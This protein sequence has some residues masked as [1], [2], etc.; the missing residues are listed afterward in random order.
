MSEKNKG[1]LTMGLPRASGK[2]RWCGDDGTDEVP[3]KVMCTS[4]PHALCAEDVL[5]HPALT[6]AHASTPA[7]ECELTNP[8]AVCDDADGTSTEVTQEDTNTS[9]SSSSSSSSG[10]S[11]HDDHA[12]TDDDD[13]DSMD[14]PEDFIDD[15]EDKDSGFI[16]SNSIDNSSDEE[17]ERRGAPCDHSSSTCPDTS[18]SSSTTTSSTTTPAST[19]LQLS[20]SQVLPPSTSSSTT[21]SSTTS[22]STTTTTS[23]ST[24]SSTLSITST[25]S[26]STQVTTILTS[27]PVTI[28]T[29]SPLSPVTILTAASPLAVHTSTSAS[30]TLTHT[31]PSSTSSSSP[32]SSPPPTILAPETTSL[33]TIHTSTTTTPLLSPPSPPPP[34]TTTSSTTTTT[35]FLL[36]AMSTT[37]TTTTTSSSGATTSEERLPGALVSDA[38]ITT[39]TTAQTATVVTSAYQG[40]LSS[41]TYEPHSYPYPPDTYPSRP[42]TP[43]WESCNFYDGSQPNTNKYMEISPTKAGTSQSI[44]C[45]ENGK[46]Y[47]ELGSASPY[48]HTYSSDCGNYTTSPSSYPSQS[49]NQTYT[50]PSSYGQPNTYYNS[51]QSYSP[52]PY[53][54][55]PNSDNYGGFE[56]DTGCTYGYGGN[57]YGGT[58]GTLPPSRGPPRCLSPYCDPTRGGA[59]PSCYHQ[60]RL[61]VLNVSMYKLNRFRQFPDPS[62]HRSVLICNTLRHIEREL[63]AEGVSVASILA[64]S[65]AAHSHLQGATPNPGTPPCPEPM[66]SSP[67]SSPPPSEGPLPPMHTP[68]VG[69]PLAAPVSPAPSTPVTPSPVNHYSTAG[70]T[71]QYPTAQY[72]PAE[73]SSAYDSRETVHLRPYPS[74]PPNSHHNDVGEGPSGVVDTRA[75]PEDPPPPTTPR[76]PPLPPEDRTDA[77]NWCSVLSLSSQTD[78]DSMNNNEY[79]DW[80]GEGSSDLDYARPDDAPPWKLPSLSADD[81]LKSFPEASKRLEAT[82]D[83]DS[84]I[85]VLV[86]S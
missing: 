18:T 29:T 81:V 75:E 49:Y 60:Q 45:D 2:R 30:H 57:S 8:A 6:H 17:V 32:P 52:N 31:S 21:S 65:H 13:D 46:S 43:S 68:L 28:H 84:I 5:H 12:F 72:L 63:E 47:M 42:S 53:N 9:S 41:P 33:L 11:L 24:T 50:S 54:V 20:L 51:R 15:E 7:Q 64:H 69:S 58:R 61:S 86:G 80:S 82:E 83:L 55:Y 16:D 78:L 67:P 76:P 74:L 14:E 37:T 25:I 66:P 40:A 26:P 70:P 38:S 36:S 85:N 77:I 3:A 4:P 62:L 79:G 22:S 48:T 44:Q 34:S 35:A 59:R 27:S 19:S 56:G 73:H 23:S 10:P 1:H 71:V 39:V